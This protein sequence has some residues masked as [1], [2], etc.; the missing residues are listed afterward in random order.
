MRTNIELDQDLVQE[1]QQL[2]QIKTKRAL[3]HQALLEFVANRKRLDLRELEGS[4]LL[5][6]EYDHKALRQAGS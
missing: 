2:S 4:N 5:D 3:V 6:L 1:A